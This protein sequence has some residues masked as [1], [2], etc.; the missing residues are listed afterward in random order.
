MFRGR[1]SARHPQPRAAAL[2]SADSSCPSVRYRTDLANRFRAAAFRSKAA[3][4]GL[5]V[6][7]RVTAI[8]VLVRIAAPVALIVPAIGLLARLRFSGT[9][10]RAG[11]HARREA[12]ESRNQQTNSKEVQGFHGLSP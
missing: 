7:S 4:E 6:L 3:F 8:T 10:A 12:E 2:R 9:A 5:L 1:R 11:E